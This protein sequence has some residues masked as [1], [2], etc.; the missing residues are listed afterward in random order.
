[1]GP[2]VGSLNSASRTS[3][4]PSKRGKKTGG[5]RSGPDISQRRASA[6][7]P[8]LIVGVTGFEPATFCTPCRRASQVTLHPDMAETADPR[9]GSPPPPPNI[10]DRPHVG[11]AAHRR[12]AYSRF[13]CRLRRCPDRAGASPFLPSSH[14][15]AS[16]GFLSASSWPAFRGGLRTCRRFPW[17]G[18]VPRPAWAGRGSARTWVPT[19]FVSTFLT[20]VAGGR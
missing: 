20:L 19:F 12:A 17:P 7:S 4:R 16:F 5:A 3:V 13:P 11:N 6:T 14:R 9:A 18:H 10:P 8:V 15:R 2:V 1:M